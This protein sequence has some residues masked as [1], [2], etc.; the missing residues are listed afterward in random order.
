[1]KKGK[2]KMF[3]GLFMSVFALILGGY[4][5][6]A[7][8]AAGST[9][10]DGTA[11]GAA[12][13]DLSGGGKTVEGE[14]SLT[15]TEQVMD[16]EF[17]VKEVDR[18]ICEMKFTGTPIDQILRHATS[19]QSSSIVVK[20]YA[21][22]QRPLKTTLTKALVES[23]KGIP[24]KLEVSDPTIFGT[25]DTILVLDANGNY[26]NGYMPDGATIDVKHPLM[27][28]VSSKS[29]DT[30]PMVY[31]VNGKAG[32]S[33][34][35]NIPT[36]PVGTCLLRLGRA[37]GEKD[38]STGAYYNL[39]EPTEQY[40]QRFIMQ[41]EDTIYDRLSKKEVPWNF[42]DIE[43][44]AVD[45]M[46]IGIEASGLF[47]I[48]SKTVINEKG[49]VYTQEGIWYR[50]GKD[51]TLGH[52]ETKDGNQE[53]I[54][55][56]DELVDFVNTIIDGAGNGSRTKLFFVDNTLYA[57]LCK[58][59]TNKTRVLQGVENFNDWGLD[60]DSFSSMGTKLLIYRHDLFNAWGMEGRGFVLDPNYMDKWV[61]QNWKRQEFDLRELFIS[62]GGAVTMEE[63]SCWTLQFPNAHARVK[64]ADKPTVVN[65]IIENDK[66]E[67]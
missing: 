36:L 64:I 19:H 46:R 31:A 33:K 22:G 27:L 30:F 40:C 25:M 32:G 50:A 5:C 20:Y 39:P 10:A 28:R 56:E 54:V 55:T 24:V 57:A 2:M 65:E 66:A 41:V 14:M 67:V 52:W 29:E 62:N 12:V 13:G 34:N 15:K 35:I 16:A 8:M 44:M 61:F 11:A 18:R 47:G 63:F 43:R 59:K 58:I 9:V 42:T 45:D 38:V 60:F 23:T 3:L 51:I 53:F 4:G 37:A 48:K 21:I 17:Y 26:V 49:N 6:G 1:M 7:A